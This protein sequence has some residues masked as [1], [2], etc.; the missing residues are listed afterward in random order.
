M[1]G[2]DKAAL[3]L[4]GRPFLDHQIDVLRTVVEDVLL[5]DRDGRRAGPSGIRVVA[6]RIP[7]AGALGGVFTALCEARADRVLVVACDMPFL[8][9]GFASFLLGQSRDADVTIPRDALGRFPVCGVFHRRVTP[10]LEARIARGEF[11][12]ADALD[13]LD[14]RE[15][16]AAA[17]AEFDPDGRLLAN[18]N[19]PDDYRDILDGHNT[20]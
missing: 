12:F 7:G 11:G 8:T 13:N 10:A 4:D 3:L 19:T 9:P 20:P 2:A 5:V 14:V 6:D 18:V 1:G 17:L 15:I 16:D